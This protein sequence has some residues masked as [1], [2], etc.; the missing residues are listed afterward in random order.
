[1]DAPSR[2][3][4]Y[5]ELLK[6]QGLHPR[7]IIMS[8]HLVSEMDYLFDE[9]I[10]IKEGRVL[11]KESYDELVSRGVTVIGGKQSIEKFAEGKEILNE[12]QL[13]DTRSITLYGNLSEDERAFAA[14]LGLNIGPV[15]LQDLFIQL[16]KEEE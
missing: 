2:D 15:S 6:D 12:E 5:K 16:T 7:I 14:E 11:L 9:V 13:G 10:I 1:M 4:F 3:L 8:T